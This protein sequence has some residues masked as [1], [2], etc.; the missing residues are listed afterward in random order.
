MVVMEKQSVL[1][2]IESV[3]ALNGA[4]FKDRRSNSG[5]DSIIFKVVNDVPAGNPAAAPTDGRWF[6]WKVF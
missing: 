4:N 3:L 2:R 5:F 1:L 6:R